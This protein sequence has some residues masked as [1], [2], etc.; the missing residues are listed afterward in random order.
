[1]KRP[2]SDDE[3]A[4]LAVDSWFLEKLPGA[5]LAQQKWKEQTV[6]DLRLVFGITEPGEIKSRL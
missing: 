4:W 1:M 6:A 5:R 2:I 3:V